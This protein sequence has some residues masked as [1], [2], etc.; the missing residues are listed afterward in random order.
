[1]K[2]L[3]ANSMVC[4]SSKGI[5]AGIQYPVLQPEGQM[6][7]SSAGIKYTITYNTNIYNFQ[8][9]KSSESADF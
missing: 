3:C 8:D 2:I 6:I 1:M 5:T 9:K 7:K 4:C